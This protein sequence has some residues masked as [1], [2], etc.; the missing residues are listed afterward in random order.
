MLSY[1]LFLHRKKNLPTC[2]WTLGLLFLPLASISNEYGNIG[3]SLCFYFFGVSIHEYGY[4]VTAVTNYILHFEVHYYILST[5]SK[6]K[7]FSRSNIECSYFNFLLPFPWILCLL[8]FWLS[9][10]KLCA[11]LDPVSP[12]FLSHSWTMSIADASFITVI[13]VMINKDFCSLG[14]FLCQDKI[15]TTVPG[16]RWRWEGGGDGVGLLKHVLLWVCTTP[17]HSALQCHLYNKINGRWGGRHIT[18]TYQNVASM[19]PFN[20]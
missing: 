12:V 9:A 8:Q 18:P 15:Q 17:L 5:F 11:W 3:L 13:I 4:K 1:S 19:F 20:V 2:F 10:W 7:V 6:A 14:D 16:G